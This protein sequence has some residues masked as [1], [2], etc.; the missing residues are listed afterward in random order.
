MKTIKEFLPSMLQRNRG[1]I[2]STAS[3]AGCTGLAGAVDYCSSKFAAVGL[4]ESLRRELASQGKTGIHF[5]TV[6][7]SLISTGM[8]DGVR[9]R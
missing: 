2:V 7:P 3:I 1:H 5:T 8:F 6:C 9:F 4:M